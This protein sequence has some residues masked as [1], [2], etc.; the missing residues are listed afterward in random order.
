M[1]INLKGKRRNYM[2]F[3][4]GIIGS[5]ILIEA[6]LLIA[7]KVSVTTFKRHWE[8]QIS[9]PPEQHAIKYVAFGDSTAQGIGATSAERGYVGLVA[10]MLAEKYGRPVQIL[11]FSATGAVAKDVITKQLPAY[12]KSRVKAD[13]VTMEIGAND[14]STYN[15]EMFTKEFDEICKR[16][17]A[18]A[19]VSDLPW[20]GTRASKQPTT[21]SADKIVRS[22]IEK[23]HLRQVNLTEATRKANGPLLYAADLFHPSNHAYKIWAT[24]FWEQVN[25]I[26]APE[27]AY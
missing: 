11:N 3:F 27:P 9:Q 4:V 2:I 7:M 13:F 1:K 19:A 24:A 21:L 20:F 23:Y 14:V 26:P 25:T 17:P 8:K 5:L 12:E 15:E 22:T 10:R 18:G 6:G 16:L